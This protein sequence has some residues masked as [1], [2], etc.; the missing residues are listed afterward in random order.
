[1]ATRRAVGGLTSYFYLIGGLAAVGATFV[2]GWPDAANLAGIRVIGAIAM[3]A[4]CVLFPLRALTPRWV[5]H[6]SVTGGTVLITVVIVLSHSA[7]I[8]LGVATIYAYVMLDSLIFFGWLGAGLQVAFCAAAAAWSL[9][10]EEVALPALVML[11][12]TGMA[13]AFVTAWLS[14]TSSAAHHDQV[15]RLYNQ[16]GFELRAAPQLEAAERRGEPLAYILLDL[17]DF[18]AFNDRNGKHVG[19][20]VLRGCA[21]SWRELIGSSGILGRTGGDQFAVVLRGVGTGPAA[22]L[23]DQLRARVPEGVTASAG[24]ARMMHGETFSTLRSHADVALLEAKD[25]GRDRTVVHGDP[26]RAASEL[27]AAVAGG[28][29]VLHYQPVVRLSDRERVSAEALVRW[30]HP[31][32]GAVAPGQFVPLAERTGAIHALGAW[33][34]R[35]AARDAVASGEDGLGSVAVNLSVYELRSPEFFERVRATIAETGI[36]PSRLTFEIT[37]GVF[38]DHDVRVA[39][40]LREL[41]SLG[42]R[43]AIDDFGAGYSSLR[44]LRTFPSDILKIDASFVWAIPEDSDEDP[45]LAAIIG[46]AKSLGKICVAEGIETEHQADVLTKLGCDLGQGYLFG[47]PVPLAA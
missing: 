3:A 27:E 33:T 6:P 32:K 46:M 16:R 4:A 2:P 29:M 30:N 18:K 43:V 9:H 12:I 38:D 31:E 23:A 37:E 47:R 36:E 41:R 15:T 1:M 5:Y 42:A 13:C 8:G 21:N 7:T 26:D 22:D 39:E 17:D 10:H 25:S 40:T 24:V 28:Q 11:L 34:M 19:D 14:R 20:R 35:E 44:W 45:M